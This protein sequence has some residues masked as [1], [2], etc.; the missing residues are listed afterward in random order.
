MKDLKRRKNIEFMPLKST[1]IMIMGAGCWFVVITVWNI[2]F[3]RRS[4]GRLLGLR[5]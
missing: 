3:K 5:F 4:T 1:A 2:V